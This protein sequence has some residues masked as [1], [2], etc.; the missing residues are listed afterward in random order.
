[1]KYSIHRKL[2]TDFNVFEENKLDARSYFIPFSSVK[3]LVKTDF[4]NERYSS[5][6]VTLLN[7]EWDFAYYHTN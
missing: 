1:M 4:K 3:R 5:D 2:H 7:G 6:R